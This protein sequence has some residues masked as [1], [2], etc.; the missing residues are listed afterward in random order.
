MIPWIREILERS[1]FQNPDYLPISTDALRTLLSWEFNRIQIQELQTIISQFN[2]SYCNCAQKL[3]RLRILTT[4]GAFEKFEIIIPTPTNDEILKVG[5]NCSDIAHLLAKKISE[6]AI[7]EVPS[8]Q[9]HSVQLVI[10]AGQN[11]SHF[12]RGKHVWLGLIQTDKPVNNMVV[13]DPSYQQI[14]YLKTN[15]YVLNHY[16]KITDISQEKT[17]ILPRSLID[18][19]NNSIDP[20]TVKDIVLGLSSD[21]SV[22]FSIGFTVSWNYVHINIPFIRIVH[23]DGEN[24][25]ICL[26]NPNSGYINWDY[27][28]A[29]FQLTK[30]SE[31]ELLQLLSIAKEIRFIPQAENLSDQ[32]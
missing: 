27:R 21:R 32:N 24:Q 13:L 6:N 9:R 25:A 20:V 19:R 8:V 2:K 10:A 14:S 29:F 17:R 12:K 15:H 28:D 30:S 3:E 7:L 23:E 4:R 31:N 18:I 11:P 16:D 1:H 22:S 5:G 26:I